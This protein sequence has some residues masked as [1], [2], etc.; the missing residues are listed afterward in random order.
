ME[1]ELPT[2]CLSC[3]YAE[4]SMAGRIARN[5][6]WAVFGP[7]VEERFTAHS[8]VAMANTRALAGLPRKGWYERHRDA[9]ERTGDERE[10]DRMLRHVT[11]E[12]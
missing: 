5:I 12:D 10:L 4:L 2:G 7:S 11:E 8:E 3:R 6:R 1:R 9:F